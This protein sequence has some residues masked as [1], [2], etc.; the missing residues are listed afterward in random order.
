MIGFRKEGRAGTKKTNKAAYFRVFI[1][2]LFFFLLALRGPNCW[3]GGLC[4]QSR[5]WLH[6]L[7][8]LCQPCQPSHPL[9]PRLPSSPLCLLKCYKQFHFHAK[10]NISKQVS[11]FLLTFV[12]HSVL[13]THS[14]LF[15]F[16]HSY[17]PCG[18]L[19]G[20]SNWHTAK[21]CNYSYLMM[22]F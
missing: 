22:H 2:F 4:C 19:G 7:L 1:G 17:Q 5:N 12:F 6:S 9:P 8:A 21:T 15:V 13:N 14:H 16:I 11:L 20:G 10:R 18:C 3:Q